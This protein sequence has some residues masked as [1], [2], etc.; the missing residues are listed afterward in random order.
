MKAT[1]HDQNQPGPNKDKPQNDKNATEVR[2][3]ESSD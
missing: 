2:H 1:E 3:G